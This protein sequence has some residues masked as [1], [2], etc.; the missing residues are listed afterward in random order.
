M[1]PVPSPVQ[2]DVEA[3]LVHQRDRARSIAVHFEQETAR[4]EA[5]LSDLR[6][7]LPEP[8]PV[9]PGRYVLRCPVCGDASIREVEHVAATASIRGT[10]V[11][12]GGGKWTA[13]EDLVYGDAEY[14]DFQGAEWYECSSWWDP[15]HMESPIGA[16]W[17]IE[18]CL[19]PAADQ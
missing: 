14:G 17:T 13:T 10:V 12:E 7:E 6:V 8:P 5:E 18:H 11:Y 15:Q 2:P 1:N 4:L 16:R 19:V 9:A 3:E